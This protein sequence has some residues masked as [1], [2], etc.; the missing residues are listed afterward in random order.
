ME[1]KGKPMHE[2]TH[3]DGIDA[4]DSEPVVAQEDEG[5]REESSEGHERKLPEVSRV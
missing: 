4:E 2:E 3:V 5:V 1:K